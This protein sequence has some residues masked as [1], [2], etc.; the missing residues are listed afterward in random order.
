MLELKGDL[1]DT[2]CDALC[3][4]TNGF[5]KANGENVMGRG[6]AQQLASY[7]PRIPKLLGVRIKNEGNNVHTLI[8]E[9]D[10]VM[11][12]FPVKPIT[13]Y[14]DKNKTNVVKHMRSEFKAND[15]VPGWACIASIKIITRS[16]KQLV[17]LADKNGWKKVLIPRPGCGHGELDW[18]DVKPVLDEIL[19]DRFYAITFE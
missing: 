19:D 18:N 17:K 9:E 1:F 16:A 4:T 7:F 10:T 2:E 5:V 8:M 13:N 11:L 14:C 3:I 15:K 12:S 6:C